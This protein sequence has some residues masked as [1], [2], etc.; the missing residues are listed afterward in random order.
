MMAKDWVAGTNNAEVLAKL[1]GELSSL[2]EAVVRFPAG[3]PALT[4]LLTQVDRLTAK[5]KELAAAPVQ[6]SGYRYYP[7]GEFFSEAWEAMTVAER[8]DFLRLHQVHL[9]FTRTNG[10]VPERNLILNDVRSVV[11]AIDP[12]A[13]A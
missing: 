12:E 1:D 13:C 8:N 3:S 4:G 2:A 9:E 5:R 11:R 6:Q 7:T 10:R